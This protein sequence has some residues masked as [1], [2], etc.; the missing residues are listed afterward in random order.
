MSNQQDHNQKLQNYL[1]QLKVNEN[2]QKIIKSSIIEKKNTNTISILETLKDKTDISIYLL[3]SIIYDN[4]EIVKFIIEKQSVNVLL[5]LTVNPIELYSDSDQSHQEHDKYSLVDIPLLILS[6]IGGSIE[7]FDY[8]LKKG[9]DITQVGHIGLSPK[10]K[11]SIVSNVIGAA[12]YYKRQY[13][14]SYLLDLKIIREANT[15]ENGSSINYL[16]LNYKSIEKKIKLKSVSFQKELTGYTPIMLC[17]VNSKDNNKSLQSIKA[18]MNKVE[19]KVVDFENNNLLHLS[20]KY[21]SLDIVRFLIEDMGFD[22]NEVNSKKESAFMLSQSLNG[23]EMRVINEYLKKVEVSQQRQKNESEN[24][25]DLEELINDDKQR[26]GKNKKKKKKKGENEEVGFVSNFENNKLITYEEK[27]KKINE[28]DVNKKNTNQELACDVNFYDGYDEDEKEEVD[29]QVFNKDNKD[30]KNNKEKENIVQSKNNKGNAYKR[31]INAY[32]SYD[33]YKN[34]T[35]YSD[36]SQVNDYSKVNEYNYNKDYNYDYKY[37]KQNTY[38]NY[39]N[40]YSQY[41]KKG[42]YSKSG[43]NYNKEK[44]SRKNLYYNQSNENINLVEKENNTST[45]VVDDKEMEKS[46]DKYEI[47]DENKNNVQLVHYK[48]SLEIND[49]NPI[50]N[51]IKCLEEE[52]PTIIE[53][54]IVEEENEKLK[55]SPSKAVIIEETNIEQEI[56]FDKKQIESLIYTNKLLKRTISIQKQEIEALK[57]SL[58]QISHEREVPSTEENI[59][60]LLELANSQISKK[61]EEINRLK[62]LIFYEDLQNLSKINR[63]DLSNLLDYHKK[64]VVEIEKLI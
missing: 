17:V 8:I 59:L 56:S 16:S 38:N 33:K 63:E 53:E 7:I 10:K 14:L 15:K 55:S 57:D 43:Y 27:E 29:N 36:Y 45:C 47:E 25:N 26:K 44:G 5:P 2:I 50:K 30:N 46:K 64:F 18:L 21:T 48:D 60:D 62:K 3:Y 52:N 39:T 1:S 32:G 51:T 12:S 35:E 11:N 31:N 54:K 28:K 41:N 13:M 58:F 19:T 37:N 20:V 40:Q 61:V 4:I 23:D 24:M 9:G 49:T 34:Y 22:I 6:A 42:Y